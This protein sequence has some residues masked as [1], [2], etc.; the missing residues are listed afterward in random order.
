MVCVQTVAAMYQAYER[1]RRVV[2]RRRRAEIA[3]LKKSTLPVVKLVHLLRGARAR[4]K[5]KD[6]DKDSKLKR[7]RTSTAAATGTASS[8]K[9]GVAS[10]SLLLGPSSFTALVQQAQH[11][12]QHEAAA[13]ATGAPPSGVIPQQAVTSTSLAHAGSPTGDG[14][15]AAGRH[16]ADVV[17]SVLHH[18]MHPPAH[19]SDQ[20]STSAA[21]GS[22]V[23]P[24]SPRVIASHGHNHNGKKGTDSPNR[25]GNR[26]QKRPKRGRFAALV[27]SLT[28]HAHAS[29]EPETMGLLTHG[30][31]KRV[32]VSAHPAA[33]NGADDGAALV[34]QDQ[35]VLSAV[36]AGT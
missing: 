30:W 9:S 7:D 20:H 24:G 21:P 3:R 29:I 28:Q 4:R 14:A 22:A 31:S 13:A 23:A 33:A 27:R 11:Q 32:L 15:S 17:L 25:K 36:S 34:P 2:E 19:G 18:S 12:H 8:P 26:D 1:S 16:A 35:G 10:R 6:K 5:D